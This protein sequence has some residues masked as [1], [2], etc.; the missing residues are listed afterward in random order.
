MI[1]DDSRPQVYGSQIPDIDRKS[2]C[3][4]QTLLVRIES[5]SAEENKMGN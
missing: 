3:C 5:D 1:G 2:S 4:P